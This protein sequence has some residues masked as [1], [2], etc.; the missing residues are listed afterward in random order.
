MFCPNLSDPEIK[1]KF[2]SL[3]SVYPEGAYYLWDKFQGEVPAKYYNVPQRPISAGRQYQYVPSMSTTEIVAS[4]KTLRDLAARMASRIGLPYKIISDRNEKFKGRIENG[5]AIINLAYASL[6][7]PI[8]EI[9]GH[10]I[11]RAIKNGIDV[12]YTEYLE[13]SDADEILEPGQSFKK[14]N[15]IYELEYI[16][17]DGNRL[18]RYDHSKNIGQ[19]NQLYQNLLKELETGVGKDVLDRVKRDYTVREQKPSILSEFSNY[20]VQI[21]DYLNV[22]IGHGHSIEKIV[23]KVSTEFPGV[24][25][26]Y[27][28]FNYPAYEPEFFGD[29]AP[30]PKT[31][32]EAVYRALGV[33]TDGVLYTLE[34][35]QEEAIVELLGLMT[36]N[37]L[38]AVKDGKLMSLLKRLL[39]EMKLFMKQLLGLKEVEI[40]NLPDNM[41]LGDLSD[42]LAYSNSKLILPGNE[43][44]YTTPDNQQFKTYAEASKHISELAKSVEDVDLSNITVSTELTET[45]KEKIKVLEQEIQTL[46]KLY[47]S[48]EYK[49]ETKEKLQTLEAEKDLIL[50]KEIV[51]KDQEPNL[52]LEDKK[53]YEFNNFAY[54]RVQNTEGIRKGD[55][56]EALGDY[57]GY[58]IFGYNVGG[59]GPDSK[60]L[61]VTKEEA[62]EIW[63]K[64]F[65]LYPEG[66]FEYQDRQKLSRLYDSINDL[67]LGNKEKYAIQKLEYKIDKIKEGDTGGISS[68]IK[69]NKEYEQA[70]EIIEEWKKVN[71]IQY[72]PE[73]VYS[74]GQEFVS[75]VGAYSSFDVNL[76]MQNLL[77]HIEDNKKAGGEF[78]ISVFTKPIDIQKNQLIMYD[79]GDGNTSFQ[80]KISQK[81]TINHINIRITNQDNEDIGTLGDWNLTMQFERHD[82]DITESLLTQ[83]KQ[84]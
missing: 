31:N 84:K 72:N 33:N 68:F 41:T 47:N 56:K 60:I 10:P 55:H 53:K 81:D 46:K 70:K 52:N 38:D 26:E 66:G 18:F 16:A 78:T 1:R 25:W 54:T 51:F 19:N 76:M 28:H 57:S 34:E 29:E 50:N 40:N 30:S 35:Q 3:K 39:K 64:A 42:L 23:Q 36:A 6:D 13:E 82:E 49:A 48:E 59:E 11:I 63:K 22:L 58:Y 27:M 61:K 43:V 14:N 20:G 80:Y 44:I 45:E 74:R 32:L 8:H 5:E 7:T 37:K 24:D 21:G 62:E 67:K 77:Q 9:L 4:E 15:L 71:N 12:K 83:I 65:L 73:E 2:E 17:S 75:V 69:R 79:N